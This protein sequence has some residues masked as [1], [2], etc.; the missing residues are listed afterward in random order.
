MTTPRFDSAVIIP[1][2]PLGWPWSGGPSGTTWYNTGDERGDKGGQTL[3]DTAVVLGGAGFIGSHLVDRLL[4]EGLDVVVL[5]N[6]ATGSPA[7]LVQHQGHPERVRIITQDV[8]E[9]FHAE[10]LGLSAARY[11]FQLASP[12]SPVHYRR[13]SL[14]TLTANA[15]GTWHALHLAQALG[16]RFILASTSE[17]YGDPEIS[18][19]P[20]TYWGHVNPIGE[21]SCYDEGKRFAE[22]LTM[23]WYRRHQLDV[24]IL[25]F[26]NCYGPRMQTEDGRVVPNFISQALA[27]QPLTVYG[28]GRQTRSFCYVSDEVDGIYRAA[29]RD[30][31][32]GLVF[33]I[34]N[35]EEHTILEFAQI[36]AE[37]AGVA[38]TTV[39]RPLPPDDPTRRRPDIS[40]ARH[41]LD[42]EPKVPLAQGLARTI[43]DFRTRPSA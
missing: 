20:E 8:S 24:R 1:R 25:R 32:A 36:V 34:G 40:R 22:A 17:V 15:L 27:G 35:P 42:W 43:E 29:S 11:V 18:P 23:E 2:W 39:N 30:G 21:R 38:L 3:A 6:F 16:A 10:G 4:A 13:L 37:V 26:F 31:L 41:L 9:P 19:Q 28:D 7:N 33:N 12:A 5:D 14:E